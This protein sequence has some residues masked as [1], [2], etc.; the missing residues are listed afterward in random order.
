MLQGI[1]LL[2]FEFRLQAGGIIQTSEPLEHSGL[3]GKLLQELTDF[4]LKIYTFH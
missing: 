2:N 1:E 4:I 3:R